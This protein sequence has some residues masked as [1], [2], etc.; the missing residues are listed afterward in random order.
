MKLSA[1]ARAL[2]IDGLL[3]EHTPEPKVALFKPGCVV[4]S[5]GELETLISEQL[6]E[7]SK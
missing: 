2:L 5:A 6:D 1:E 4:L 3:S 7:E